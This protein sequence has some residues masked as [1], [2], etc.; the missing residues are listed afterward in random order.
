MALSWV[1]EC[2]LWAPADHL[3]IVTPLL[4]G[5]AGLRPIVLVFPLLLKPDRGP[6]IPPAN[7]V[8]CLSSWAR[9]KS[10]AEEVPP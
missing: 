9:C 7:L 6:E 5:P 10:L 4:A 1:P 3:S 2:E 8:S